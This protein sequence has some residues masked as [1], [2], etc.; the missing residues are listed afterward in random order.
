MKKYFVCLLV[1]FSISAI[2]Y[3]DDVTDS[4][5]EALANYKKGNYSEAI[6]NL[7]Y[8]SQMV[9][10]KKSTTLGDLLPQPL[11]GWTAQDVES[12]AV[13]GAMFGGMVS[14]N[15]EYTKGNSNITITVMTDSPMMQTM[16]MFMSNPMMATS[17]GMKI[18]KVNGQKAVVE[19]SAKNNKGTMH[20]VVA[21][22]VLV[23]VN[24]NGVD[25]KVIEQYAA[26]IDYKKLENIK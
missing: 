8:A 24:G 25:L 11:T 26:A 13:G 17:S 5:D 12:Q 15:R 18:K 14:A 1:L 10:Q 9:R 4:I 19:Y 6:S 21:N 7:D 3:A 2:S 16:M 23:T 20:I 22:K